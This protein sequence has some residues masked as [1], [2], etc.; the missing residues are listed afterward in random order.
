MHATA[1]TTGA[2][3]RLAHDGGC[4]RTRARMRTGFTLIELLIVVTMMGIASAMVI[5][6]MASVG[7][8]R[9]QAAVRTLVG[10]IT[11]IQSEALANQ[12]RY[13][14]A[15]GRVT[16]FDTASNQWKVVE[17]NG[18]TIFAP[19]IGATTLDLASTLDVLFD[20]LDHGR[21][22]SR[23]FDDATYAGAQ[24]QDASFNNGV[25]LIYDELGGPVLALTGDDPG[26]GGSVR[27]VGPDSAF[28]VDVDAFTGRVEVARVNP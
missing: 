15:F 23:D 20:P 26:A 2:P 14:M 22:M 11:F 25:L 13:V 7:V 8:L 10:D 18:Y 19:P 16:R 21:P 9:I 12:S 1:L 17:G 28:R 4:P 24:I 3:R 27:V 6:S 5:P